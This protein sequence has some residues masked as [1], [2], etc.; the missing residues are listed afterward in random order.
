M[1]TKVWKK[2]GT[3]IIDKEIQEAANLLKEG[4]VVA[5]PTETV[6]GLGADATN[7]AA[8]RKIFEAKGRPQDNPLIAHVAS[9]EQLKELV[10][11]IPDYVYPLMEAFSPGPL[12]YILPANDF[13]AE[14]VKAGLSTIGV[15]IPSHPIALALLQA[16]GKPVAAPS[17]NVSGKPSPTQAAH[18]YEDL[19]GKISGLIDGGQTGV[20]L[21]STVIDCTGEIPVIL[22]PGGV[23]KEQLEAEAGTVMIDPGLV[24]SSADRP[25]APGMKYKHYAPEVPLYLFEGNLQA[26]SAFV[27]KEK[28]AGNRIGVLASNQSAEIFPDGT[29]VHLLG[30]TIEEIASSLY[31]GLRFFKHANVDKIVCETFPEQGIGQA[32]MNRLRKAAD[33]IIKE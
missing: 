18:V 9:A 26:F 7:E 16:A 30:G 33:Q 10:T 6:Y 27:D 13:C 12:T 15:R 29:K 21:E 11:Y 28:Q 17:A 25:K 5:F 8:V 4:E 2:N 3:T 19:N 20:G 31:D 1:H 22:R 14:N 32:V 23:T 24:T